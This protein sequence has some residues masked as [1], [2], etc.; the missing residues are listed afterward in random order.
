M[1]LLKAQARASA[2]VEYD[3]LEA[4]RKQ[5][6][7]ALFDS[8]KFNGTAT[9][10][11]LGSPEVCEPSQADIPDS[12]PGG[13][14]S[15][16]TPR[17]RATPYPV[18]RD[19]GRMV[20]FQRAYDEEFDKLMNVNQEPTKEAPRVEA[21]SSVPE[22]VIVEAQS[23]TP[24]HQDAAVQ[25]V[26]VQ[27][28]TSMIN[29]VDVQVVEAQPSTS[30]TNEVDVEAAR[31]QPSTSVPNN[32]ISEVANTQI[33]TSM[34]NNVIVE[35]TNAQP[36][37]PSPK[38][39]SMKDPSMES[40]RFSSPTLKDVS[41]ES[42][43]RGSPMSVDVS[44]ELV[45]NVLPSPSVSKGVPPPPIQNDCFSVA[46]GPLSTPGASSSLR[47]GHVKSSRNHI[48]DLMQ[49]APET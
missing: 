32:P 34:S 38:D 41:V 12:N 22:E 43:G 20:V 1:C 37:P 18:I 36:L 27:P 47:I 45:G 46:S 2:R 17:H 33:P 25:A 14:K 28:S 7:K 29:V 26:V 3:R 48:P 44:M 15:H 16:P 4:L 21:S 11:R 23:S 30:T 9:R 6:R 49:V 5:R 8:N 10:L 19:M 13:K 42:D 35:A 24:T 39:V 40:I 31:V